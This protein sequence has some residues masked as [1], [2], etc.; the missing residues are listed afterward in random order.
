MLFRVKNLRWESP[1][2]KTFTSLVLLWQVFKPGMCAT[3]EFRKPDLT[4]GLL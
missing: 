3:R 4:F 2:V 1:V